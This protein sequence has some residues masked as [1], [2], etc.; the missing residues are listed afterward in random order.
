MAEGSATGG[1]PGADDAPGAG[2]A[3]QPAAT[4]AP[5]QRRRRSRGPLLIGVCLVLAGLVLLGWVGYQY[6]GT[7][8]VASRHFD[9]ERDRLRKEWSGPASESA[10]P[11]GTPASPEATGTAAGVPGEAVALLRIPRFGDDYEVPLVQGTDLDVLANGV[12]IYDSSVAPGE[13][14][15]FAIAGHRV[16]H[17]EPFRQLLELQRGDEVIVETRTA[18]FVY[19]L[20]L[21]PSELTVD[22]HDNWVL[23]PVPGKPEQQP[24]EALITLTTC[25]DLFHSPD[26][27]VGFGRLDRVEAK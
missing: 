15:N 16:T 8:V 4:D 5:R 2:G 19:V 21:A 26:R 7:N 27:S 6:F 20:D 9:S 14:G 12:G 17:G 25:Q 10:P 3:E 11:Q 22:E 24:T 13:V 18:I 23:A 1:D